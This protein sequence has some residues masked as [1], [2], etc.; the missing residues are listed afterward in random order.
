VS[1]GVVVA[2]LKRQARAESWK[3]IVVVVVCPM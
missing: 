3:S 1:I 2:M